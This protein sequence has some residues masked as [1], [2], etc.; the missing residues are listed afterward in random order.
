M[1]IV[2]CRFLDDPPI[3][4]IQPP[5]HYM[6][7]IMFGI[8]GL[9]GLDGTKVAG[10]TGAFTFFG[11]GKLVVLPLKALMLIV[12]FAEASSDEKVGFKSIVVVGCWLLVVGCWL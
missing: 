11:R 12:S 1:H 2:S 3:Y 9:D 8:S 4:L 5:S 10:C 6:G 7:V